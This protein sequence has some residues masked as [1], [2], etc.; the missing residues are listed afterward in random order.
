MSQLTVCAS[1]NL[2]VRFPQAAE[3]IWVRC[4]HCGADYPFGKLVPVDPPELEVVPP[5]AI[6]TPTSD[7]PDSARQISVAPI[8]EVDDRSTSR[9]KV[10]GTLAFPPQL[11]DTN[12]VQAKVRSPG[13]LRAKR[14]KARPRRNSAFARTAA[15]GVA[16]LVIGQL[17]LWW[18]PKTDPLNL[19]PRLPAPLTFLAPLSLRETNVGVVGREDEFSPG[20][21]M[22]TALR[23]APVRPNRLPGVDQVLIGTADPLYTAPE[24]RDC[25]RATEGIAVRADDGSDKWFRKL[26]ELSYCVT[27][28]DPQD[29]EIDDIVREVHKLVRTTAGEPENLLRINTAAANAIHRQNYHRKG[30]L[31]GGTVR[32]IELAGE[33]FS[34]RIELTDEA[35]SVVEVISRKDPRQQKAYDLGE[36]VVIMG[37]VIVDPSL[38]LIGYEGSEDTVVWGGLRCRI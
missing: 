5:P 31:F 21:T 29:E 11:P 19:A 9:M 10:S 27:F 18:L 24:V 7:Q 38:F 32:S 14:R 8:I 15:G 20:T 17:L 26:G 4:P 35:K 36:R 28:T 13:T 34:T 2:P 33:L 16:G 3:P 23:P 1:C 22:P 30:I 12:E 25:L 6:D 37:V